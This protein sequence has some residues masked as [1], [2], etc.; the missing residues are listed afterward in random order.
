MFFKKFFSFLLRSF[1]SKFINNFFKKRDIVLIFRR[2][3]SI[4]ENVYM[5]SVIREISKNKKKIFLFT[6]YGQLFLYNP[7]ISKLYNIRKKNFIWFLLSNL[8]GESI[9]EFK[10]KHE[11]KENH[12]VK[13]KYFL[14]F[15]P[16]NKIHLAQALSEH[17]NIGL[18]YRNLKN[19]IFF[20]EKEVAENERDIVLPQKFAVIHSTTKKLFTKNKEWKL[21]GM[22]A[23]VDHFYKINWIQIG[24]SSEPKLKNC[25]HKLDLDLRK[26]AFIIS[27][28]DF[29]V[30]YEGLFNHLASC[31]NKKNFLI[32]TGF[33]PESAFNYKNNILLEKNSNM[34]CYPCYDIECEKHNKNCL[35]NLTTEYV[36]DRIEKNL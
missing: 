4:G 1:L 21:E 23:I 29:L 3:S 2:G 28:C 13:K 7:R 27:K 36:L 15:H 6:N 18:N 26:S 35:E 33:L 17:F 32:H 14:F 11:T 30:T 5:T 34:T 9:V 10:S 22:Q 31:F 12:D 20:S 16:N 8:K 25:I 19:E 24:L